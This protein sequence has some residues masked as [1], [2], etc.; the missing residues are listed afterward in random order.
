MH[1]CVSCNGDYSSQLVCMV[2]YRLLT[3]RNILVYIEQYLY[4]NN[5]YWFNI[6]ILV[7]IIQ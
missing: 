1:F 6:S 5:K 3:M 4:S 2:Y 7:Q